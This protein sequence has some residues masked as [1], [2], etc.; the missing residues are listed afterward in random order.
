MISILTDPS[1]KI[2]ISQPSARDRT[3]VIYTDGSLDLESKTGGA[4]ALIKND[5]WPPD[6]LPF[7]LLQ[8]SGSVISSKLQDVP[9]SFAAELMAYCIALK[10]VPLELS[11]SDL[12]DSMSAILK[13]P[14]FDAL[15][16]REKL[17][18][19]SRPAFLFISAIH[20][21]RQLLGSSQSLFHIKA[22][23]G[24]LDFHSLANDGADNFAKIALASSSPPFP[25]MFQDYDFRIK[26]FLNV[27][28][29]WR[30]WS[31]ARMMHNEDHVKWCMSDPRKEVG[32][33][34]LN[35]ALT[36]WVES[37]SQSRL[38]SLILEHSEAFDCNQLWAKVGAVAKLCRD[39]CRLH[40]S[41]SSWIVRLFSATLGTPA[42]EA[43]RAPGK[44]TL[45][46]WCQQAGKI[47]T[48][49]ALHILVCP[50]IPPLLPAYSPSLSDAFIWITSQA[51]TVSQKLG[52]FDK[53]VAISH[54][55]TTKGQVFAN[56]DIRREF[57]FEILRCWCIIL[58]RRNAAR[59]FHSSL[60][61]R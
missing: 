59:P 14:A 42:Q 1:R 49:D 13:I 31:P 2:L 56:Q 15:S 8:Q 16:L 29:A 52:L 30:D 18:S 54:L 32:S 28:A 3:A 20:G 10:S 26:I 34:R 55:R 12:F 6:S 51:T 61:F 43:E 46:P 9:S 60:R 39:F 21:A 33:L 47:T 40:P 53:P 44:P 37:R 58:K 7:R 45:C 48:D 23:T 57:S 22:H 25:C 35:A 4:A 38:P 5:E 17:R 36:A 27:E 41:D 50:C 11:F 24:R 19:V